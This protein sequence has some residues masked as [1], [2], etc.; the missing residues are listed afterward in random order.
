MATDAP[1]PQQLPVLYSALE[2]L[3]STAHGKM[4]FRAFEKAPIIAWSAA[5]IWAVGAK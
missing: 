3:S 2:P 4:K 1:T 5:L